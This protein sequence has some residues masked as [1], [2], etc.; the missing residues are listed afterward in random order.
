MDK[1]LKP[2]IET[3]DC[4]NALQYY[5]QVEKIIDIIFSKMFDKPKDNLNKDKLKAAFKRHLMSDGSAKG[6]ELGQTK[7]QHYMQSDLDNVFEDVVAR[8]SSEYW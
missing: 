3:K 6:S 5:G 8:N 7:K 1:N 4:L 2:W